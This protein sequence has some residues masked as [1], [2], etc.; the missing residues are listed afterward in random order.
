MIKPVYS[1]IKKT[2]ECEERGTI[3]S[4]LII[5]KL[6]DLYDFEIDMS[7]KCVVLIGENGLGKSTILKIIKCLVDENFIELTRY[8]FETITVVNRGKSITISYEE[9]FP[10]I[11]I[12]KK[13]YSIKQEAL[14]M[15]GVYES[16]FIEDIKY[17]VDTGLYGEIFEQLINKFGIKEYCKLLSAIYF[18]SSI[19]QT[20]LEFINNQ[21]CSELEYLDANWI[22]EVKYF[23]QQIENRNYFMMS[24]AFATYYYTNS[25]FKLVKDF[26]SISNYYY[27]NMVQNIEIQN[28]DASTHPPVNRELIAFYFPHKDLT[29]RE[30]KRMTDSEIFMNSTFRCYDT[31]GSVAN[32]EVNELKKIFIDNNIGF[33]YSDQTKLCSIDKETNNEVLYIN[34]IIVSKYYQKEQIKD[35]NAVASK[36]F[37]DIIGDKIEQIQDETQYEE[38]EKFYKENYEDIIKYIEPVIVENSI[39]DKPFDYL[40]GKLPEYVVYD[41][42]DTAFKDFYYDN[43]EKIKQLHSK[44][45]TQIKQLLEMFLFNKTIEI[46]NKRLKILNQNGKAVDINLLSSGEKKIIILIA[47]SIF[48]DDYSLI[49]DEPELSLSI[50]WQSWLLN[51]ILNKTKNRKVIIATHSPYIVED[52]KLQKYVHPLYIDINGDK[53]N[54]RN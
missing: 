51:A 27:L 23:M 49:I 40:A 24:E 9:L 18:D 11:D 34:D 1:I 54:K 35:I 38:I 21:F 14:N 6:F 52:E 13:N 43:I 48:K 20:I 22:S 2:E 50:V 25:K 32:E 26:L 29:V 12:F 37:I 41:Q 36:Y 47:I 31:V 7:E 42:T 28:T 39:F 8:F 15:S 16:E 3:M 17:K 30:I 4:R 46:T 33:E 45:I 19:E 53:T 10:S 5:R 44:E